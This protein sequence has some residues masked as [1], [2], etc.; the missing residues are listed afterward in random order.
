MRII[1]VPI[2]EGRV[3]MSVYVLRCIQTRQVCKI[4]NIPMAYACQQR[5]SPVNKTEIHRTERP[6]VEKFLRC[7]ITFQYRSQSVSNKSK[8][9]LGSCLAAAHVNTFPDDNEE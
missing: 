1:G 6:P 9:S 8:L 7:F 3:Y 2:Y 5:G 4:G